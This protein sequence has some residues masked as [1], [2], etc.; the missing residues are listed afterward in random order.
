MQKMRSSSS[1]TPWPTAR[2]SATRTP[3]CSPRSPRSRRSSAR[4]CLG[5][6]TR[7]GRPWRAAPPRSGTG[8]PSAGR[9]RCTGSCARSSARST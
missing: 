1:S 9:T 6:W 2:P 4:R 8:S 5:R 3:R 7:P